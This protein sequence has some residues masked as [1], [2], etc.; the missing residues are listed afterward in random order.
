MSTFSPAT[1]LPAEVE[2]LMRQLRLPHARAIAAEVLATARS[3]RW[4]PTEVLKALLAEESAGRARSMLASRRK[5]AG[6]PTGKTFDVWDESASSIPLPTQQALRTLEWVRRRENLVVCGPA[7]TGKTFFLEALGQQVIEAGM[8]V[9]WFTLEQIGVLVRSHRA[10]DT[11]GKAIAKIVR[12]ELIVVDDVGLLP[13]GADAAEGLYRIVEAAY[14]RK[15]VAVSSN[16]HPSGF[17]E[18]MPKTLATATVDRLL[19]HAHLCQTS[20]DSV[21]LTQSLRGQGVTALT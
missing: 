21:R 17:D 11:L 13:V 10:D 15:S 14:E 16:L 5:A 1:V 18:L 19:H 7:G 9:A 8:P 12:A 6:F 4:D 2:A 3:Q 20:G